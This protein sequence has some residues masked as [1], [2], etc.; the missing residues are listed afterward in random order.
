MTE[1]W[2]PIEGFPNHQVSSKGRVRNIHTGNVLRMGLHNGR[3]RV[4]M[5]VGGVQHHIYTHRLVAKAFLPGYSPDL[6]VRFKD[7]DTSNADVSNLYIGAPIG[8]SLSKRTGV[9]VIETGEIFPSISAAARSVNGQTTNVNRVLNGTLRT[10]K[11]Y[12]FR[13]TAMPQAAG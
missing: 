5:T 13:F 2:A 6:G 10:H 3:L 11:G 4:S 1:H 9:E 12:T 8:H 7:G